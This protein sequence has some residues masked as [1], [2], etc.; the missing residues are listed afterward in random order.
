[1]VGLRLAIVIAAVVAAGAITPSAEAAFSGDVCGLLTAKQ[2]ATVRV[3]PLKCA[4]EKSFATPTVTNYSGNWGETG[5]TG[6][7][8]T[9]TIVLYKNS[10]V[11]KVVQKNLRTGAGFGKTKKV[12]G[13]GSLAYESK[14]GSLAWVGFV[15]GHYIVGLNL[16]TS[17]TVK[18]I[19]TLEALAKAVAGKL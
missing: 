15:V 6:P 12:S 7:E 17:G 2:V 3:T 19:S 13:I 9:M 5:A 1:M 10:N 18:S 4:A 8:L 14:S 11:F 16:R